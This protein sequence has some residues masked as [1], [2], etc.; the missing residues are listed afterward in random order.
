MTRLPALAFTALLLTACAGTSPPTYFY[1]LEAASP[2]ASAQTNTGP[3]VGLGP[4]ILPDTL[5]R[6]QI[7]TRNG[8]YG[9]EL[10][11]FHRWAGELRADMSRLMAARL[12]EQLTTDRVSLYPW[13]RHRELD[14]Q[15]RIDVLRFDGQLGGQV[16][17]EGSWTLLDAEGRKELSHRAFRLNDAG[18]GADHRAMVRAMSRLVVRLADDIAREIKGM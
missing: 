10:A 7:V 16:V 3:A 17:L 6:P 8:D 9:I 1:T 2:A 5:D 15:L 14:Y 13:P 11:E 12:M 4:V 18:A